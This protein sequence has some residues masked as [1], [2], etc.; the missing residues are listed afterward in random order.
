MDAVERVL[1]APP[2]SFSRTDAEAVN[3]WVAAVRGNGHA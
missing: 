1:G 3:V 2:H